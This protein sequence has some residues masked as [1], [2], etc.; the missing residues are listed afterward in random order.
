MGRQT[1]K[2]GD[3]LIPYIDDVVKQ[4]DVENKTITIHV[5]EGLLDE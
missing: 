1:K 2:G 4:V 3:V 5:M